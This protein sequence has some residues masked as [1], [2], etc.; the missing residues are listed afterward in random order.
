MLHIEKNDHSSSTICKKIASRYL[1]NYAHRKKSKTGHQKNPHSVYQLTHQPM[2]HVHISVD[3]PTDEL[4][5]KI[6]LYSN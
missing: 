3:T 6:G 5:T 2:N 1:Q 4:Y